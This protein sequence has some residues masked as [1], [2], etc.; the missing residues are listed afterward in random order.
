MSN[1]KENKSAI[2]QDMSKLDPIQQQVA[3]YASTAAK[4]PPKISD[5]KELFAR[6]EMEI[7][8][9]V[10]RGPE[11]DYAWLDVNELSSLNGGKWEIVNRNNHSH[12]SDRVFDASGGILYRGQNILAFCYRE[13]REAE[14]KAIVDAYNAKT[15]KI[16]KTNEQAVEGTAQRIDPGAAG[17]VVNEVDA[18]LNP[19][20]DDF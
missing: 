4:E 20:A 8:Q 7:P 12:A 14:Q 15:E 19:S 3:G 2:P 5:V 13:V 1:K 9:G 10:A 18:D 11:Y 16:T 6:I 17:K